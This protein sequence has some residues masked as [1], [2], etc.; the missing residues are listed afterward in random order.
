MQ[1]QD[2]VHAKTLIY[3]GDESQQRTHYQVRA[4]HDV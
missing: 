1:F 4:W 2:M 3:G